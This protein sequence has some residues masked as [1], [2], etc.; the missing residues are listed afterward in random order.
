MKEKPNHPSLF[1]SV[2]WESRRPAD[3]LVRAFGPLAFCYRERRSHGFANRDSRCASERVLAH[4]VI[5]VSRIRMTM[6]PKR[7][8]VRGRQ[9]QRVLATNSL[10]SASSSSLRDRPC[11]FINLT[12]GQRAIS[13]H[14][15][16]LCSIR[17][18]VRNAQ[19]ALAAEPGNLSRSVSSV[20]M[21]GNRMLKI[22]VTFNRRQP[23][24]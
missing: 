22:D 23:F 21:S 24:L 4:S 9:L 5:P 7:S 19:F 13:F 11:S 8:L 16:A 1:R 3:S 14:S 17:L 20:V 2:Y 6:S 18:K 12:F 15:S 10:S